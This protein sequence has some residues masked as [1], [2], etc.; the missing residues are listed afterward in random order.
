MLAMAPKA[1][2]AGH[3]SKGQKMAALDS[4]SGSLSKEEVAAAEQQMA[5]MANDQKEK[6]RMEANMTYYLKKTGELGGQQL[7]GDMRRQYMTL[8]LAKMMR[9]KTTAST[10]SSSH[11]VI[12]RKESHDTNE[13]MGLVQM[14]KVYGE[15]RVQ[16]WLDSK[17]LQRRPDPVTGLETDEMAEFKVPR[18]TDHN[19]GID[20]HKAGLK[21]SGDLSK[22]EDITEQEVALSSMAANRVEELKESEVS[23]GSSGGPE[24]KKEQEDSSNDPLAGVAIYQDSKGC[25]RKLRE[26]ETECNIVKEKAGDIE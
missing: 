6:R 24:I 26:M 13:W 10:T 16:G 23:A 25:L 5:A 14:Q 8:Y 7:R 11:E 9:D 12:Q 19:V 17:K 4:L 1:K 21:A 18:S 2:S 20:E 22:D 15:T 3:G